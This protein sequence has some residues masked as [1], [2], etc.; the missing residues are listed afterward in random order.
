MLYC[1][2]LYIPKV[3]LI[4]ELD[5]ITHEAMGQQRKD[6]QR[7]SFLK[8]RGYSIIRFSIKQIMKELDSVIQVIHQLIER[9]VNSP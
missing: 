8:Q 2:F 6:S 4:I 3:K 7:S 1:R 9:R 5:G